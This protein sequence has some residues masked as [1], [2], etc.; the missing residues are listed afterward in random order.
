MSKKQILIAVT[1]SLLA[2]GA[3][4]FSWISSPSPAVES[5]GVDQ[6]LAVQYVS[7]A[8]AVVSMVT[9]F[10]GLISSLRKKKSGDS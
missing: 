4:A 8:T 6:P 9:A 3:F 7:L 2:L 10:L 5:K 1:I